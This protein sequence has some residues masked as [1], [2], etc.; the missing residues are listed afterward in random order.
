VVI[1]FYSEISSTGA[2][3]KLKNLSFTVEGS[4]YGK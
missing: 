1:I 2:F 4:T 3:K